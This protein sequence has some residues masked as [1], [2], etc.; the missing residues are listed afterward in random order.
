MR[1][2]EA[3]VMAIGFLWTVFSPFFIRGLRGMSE[4]PLISTVLVTTNRISRT[5][6]ARLDPFPL[7]MSTVIRRTK[8]EPRCYLGIFS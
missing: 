6:L 2:A 3:Y 4:H 1:G 8:G 7:R 5:L